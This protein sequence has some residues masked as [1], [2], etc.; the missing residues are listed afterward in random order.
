MFDMVADPAE[1]QYIASGQPKLVRKKEER[2]AAWRRS[3]AE[4]ARM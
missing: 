4:S 1:E 3:C 2:L